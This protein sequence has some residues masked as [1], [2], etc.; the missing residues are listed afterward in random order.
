MHEQLEKNKGV[1]LK[2]SNK[3]KKSSSLTFKAVVKEDSDENMTP[4]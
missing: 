3:E 4:E 1:A 2:A